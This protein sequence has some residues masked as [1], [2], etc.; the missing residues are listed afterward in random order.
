MSWVAVRFQQAWVRVLQVIVILMD[1]RD[2]GM[3]CICVFDSIFD[4]RRSAYTAE[5]VR[6][7]LEVEYVPSKETGYALTLRKRALFCVF[8]H[9]TGTMSWAHQKICNVKF[10]NDLRFWIKGRKQLYK[11]E[12]LWHKMSP[13]KP[14]SDD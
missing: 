12:L 13:E 10:L 3:P 7:Y 8:W 11:L 4:V 14:I 5:L 9:E 2:R 6:E 1:H